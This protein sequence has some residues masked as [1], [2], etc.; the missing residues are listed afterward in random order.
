M[1]SNRYTKR[2]GRPVAIALALA[3]GTG[4]AMAQAS[5]QDKQFLKETA[6][7]SNFEIKTGQLALQKSQSE[8]VKRYATMVIHDH[9]QLKPEIRSADSAAG[10][11]PISPGSMSVEDDAKYAEMKVLTGNTFDETY[12]K[13]LVKG[14]AQ[15][16]QEAQSEASDSSVPA[17]KKLAV[18]RAALDSKHTER[19][20]QLAQAHNIQP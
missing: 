16:V 6:Q 9:T 15:A 13:G 4:V 14:N 12:I 17:V 20:K 5:T 2:F 10:V 11:E 1:T 19:A 3:M 7:D 8:D 18:R